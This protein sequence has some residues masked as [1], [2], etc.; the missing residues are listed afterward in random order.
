MGGNALKNAYMR[1]YDDD[2]YHQLV[3]EVLVILC[4]TFPA[5]RAEVIRSYRNKESFDQLRGSHPAQPQCCHT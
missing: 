3:E 1:R 2:E 4:S 5:K